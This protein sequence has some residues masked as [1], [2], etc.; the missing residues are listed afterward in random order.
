[1]TAELKREKLVFV[2]PV[3]TR[4]NK[5]RQGL[6]LY[7]HLIQVASDLRSGQVTYPS[8][9]S[10]ISFEASLFYKEEKV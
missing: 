2:L 8:R 6:N 1:M 7:G 9:L 5:Q 10:Y 4:T 3:T